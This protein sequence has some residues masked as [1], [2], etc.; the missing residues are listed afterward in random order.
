MTPD[1]CEKLRECL[2]AM[3]TA[4]VEMVLCDG[5]SPKSPPLSTHLPPACTRRCRR[6]GEARRRAFSPKC[7]N[8]PTSEV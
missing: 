4:L 3:R 1:P 6:R 8:P 2:F 7:Y 5:C